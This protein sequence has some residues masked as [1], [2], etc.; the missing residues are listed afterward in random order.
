MLAKFTAGARVALAL[1]LATAGAGELAGETHWPAIVAC[2][3]VQRRV[4]LLVLARFGPVDRLS[5]LDAVMGASSTAGL[6][7]AAG[8]APG[9]GVAAGG[10]AGGLALCR[11]RPGWRCCSRSWA[12]AALAAGPWLAPLA[13]LRRRRR[14]VGA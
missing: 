4:A 2:A 12:L 3:L 6:A 8:A 14:R 1:A 10:V 7:V 13:A 5:W 11:W 9:G